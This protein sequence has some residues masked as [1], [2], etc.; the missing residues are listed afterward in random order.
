MQGRGK[1]SIAINMKKKEGLRIVK[2]LCADA[3]VLIEPFRAGMFIRIF[4]SVVDFTV[5]LVN[6]FL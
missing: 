6:A 4:L 1:R 2:Q 5:L 3:D